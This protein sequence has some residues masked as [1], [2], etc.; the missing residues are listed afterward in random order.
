MALNGDTLG[1]AIAAA[2]LDPGATAEGKAMCEELWKK[3]AN[4]IVNHI[5][6]NAEVPA[7]IE[8]NTTTQIPPQTP[9]P[10]THTGQTTG[11]GRVI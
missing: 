8:T 1:L 6:D 9:T 11:T 10:H 2:V 4:E 5:K 3:V 7:G